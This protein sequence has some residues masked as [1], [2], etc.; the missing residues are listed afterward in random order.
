MLPKIPIV[1]LSVVNTKL[2]DNYASLDELCDDL[3]EEKEE[4]IKI[5]KTINYYY[6]EKLNQFKSEE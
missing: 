3:D 2:R 1:L 4:I 6:D 5:L